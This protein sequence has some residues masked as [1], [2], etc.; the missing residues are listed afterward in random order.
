MPAL[1]KHRGVTQPPWP[2]VFVLG[3]TLTAAGLEHVHRDRTARA[4]AEFRALVRGSA[5]GS[6]SGP[7]G[8]A[9]AATRATPT[10]PGPRELRALP[11]IGPTLATDVARWLWAQHGTPGAG[12]DTL[13]QVRGL[14]ES[15]TERIRAFAAARG[16]S[17]GAVPGRL[18]PR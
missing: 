1:P 14:G 16:A 7:E 4:A 11:G 9:L 2:L 5:P 17:Q 8:A 12:W 15:R 3:W 18:E 10:P 13:G 6:E